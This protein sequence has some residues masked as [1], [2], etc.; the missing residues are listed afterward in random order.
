M[1]ADPALSERAVERACRIVEVRRFGPYALL[2][3]A[4]PDLA[5]RA[6]P[7]QF[8]MVAVPGGSF[9]LRRPISV[10]SV[11]SERVRLLV[12]PRGS[13]TAVLAALPVGETLSVAG[14]LGRG[15]PLADVTAGLLVGGGIGTAPLQFVADELRGRGVPLVAAFGFRDAAQARLAGAFD[16]EPLWVATEDG[17]IGRRGT[18]VALLD[19]LEISAQATVFACGPTPMVAALAAWAAH[20]GSSGFASLEAHMACGSGACHGCVIPTSV[21]YKRVCSDGPVFP[22]GELEG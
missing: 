4:A 17:S 21:G 15:F 3:M 5:R 13:G 10:H 7:G 1:D 18:A 6:V 16:I 22:L 2:S 11:T 19:A 14:P 20:R 9:L 8:V 12:E